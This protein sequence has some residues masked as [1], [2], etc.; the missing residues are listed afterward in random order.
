M[1]PTRLTDRFLATY[2]PAAGGRKVSSRLW[3]G[4][5]PVGAAAVLWPLRVVDV[6]LLG[7]VNNAAYWAAVEE[8]IEPGL[9]FAHRLLGGPHRAAMEYGPGIAA[10]PRSSCC[11]TR[12]TTTWPCG[13]PSGRCRLRPGRIVA[14]RRRP[15]RRRPDDTGAGHDSRTPTCHSPG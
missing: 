2:G 7:H 8:Q 11:W 5:L 13:S 14:G 15:R 10:G 1:A 6:D 3:L 4:D 12:P 9:V